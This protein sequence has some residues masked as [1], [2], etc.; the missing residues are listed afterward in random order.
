MALSLVSSLPSDSVVQSFG[1]LVFCPVHLNANLALVGQL[2]KTLDRASVGGL[3][4][5]ALPI[6]TCRS[7]RHAV[8]LLRLVFRSRTKIDQVSLKDI[9]MRPATRHNSATGGRIDEP[10]APLVSW[11]AITPTWPSPSCPRGPMT[12]LCSHLVN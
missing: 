10:S 11:H 9:F 3:P 2:C 4:T 8:S 7:R 5:S 12:P 1:K 6:H